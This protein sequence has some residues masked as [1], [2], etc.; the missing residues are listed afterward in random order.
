V[1]CV[2][3]RGRA[4]LANAW[5][6][7]SPL[8]PFDTTR[9]RGHTSNLMQQWGRRM[10]DVRSGGPAFSQPH[11]TE[12]HAARRELAAGFPLAFRR[13]YL[14]SNYATLCVQASGGSMTLL[15]IFFIVTIGYMLF[16]S[17]ALAE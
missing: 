9:H 15:A 16:G 6:Q 12:S 10:P 2:E 7:G 4:E 13:R 17:Y 3:R 5:S 8:D 11:T 14:H 1:I